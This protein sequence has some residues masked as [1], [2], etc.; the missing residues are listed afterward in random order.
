MEILRIENV[1]KYYGEKW[2]QLIQYGRIRY[3]HTVYRGEIED[4]TQ[5]SRR[6]TH[7]KRVKV[8]L[9]GLELRR[10]HYKQRERHARRHEITEKRLLHRGKIPREFDEQVH[11]RKKECGRNYKKYS[12][13]SL[14]S[15]LPLLSLFSRF[16]VAAR[17]EPSGNNTF[18]T[19]RAARR[20]V[21]CRVCRACRAAIRSAFCERAAR[22]T[23]IS[24][25]TRPPLPPSLLHAFLPP[26]LSP[27][28]LA[29]EP[30]APRPRNISLLR[31]RALCQA[32]VKENFRKFVLIID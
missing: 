23:L 6:R 10:P 22:L 31:G 27:C 25:R 13:V 5:R 18:Y 2:R 15:Q 12:Q 7:E 9:Y 21:L 29:A 20:S 26:S 28:A 24:R 19:E 4:Y 14:F 8:A 32:Y 16:T 3:I 1:S 17:T 30:F 11:Q